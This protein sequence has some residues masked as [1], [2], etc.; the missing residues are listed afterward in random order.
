MSARPEMESHDDRLSRWVR[1]HGP[2]VAGYLRRFVP[3][4]H[5]L[6]DLVQ[7]TF[8]RA[9]VDRQKYREQE[10]ERGY[11]IQIADRLLIDSRRQRRYRISTELSCDQVPAPADM[12]PDALAA[13]AEDSDQLV[14][15]MNA[16]SEIQ[17]R[18]LL[19][20]YYGRLDFAQVASALGCPV[21]TALS[22]ARRGLLALRKILV[23][24]VL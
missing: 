9:W 3:D 15:A 24:V 18:V 22:H 10:R 14:V 13:V 20:R 21:N 16:L 6:D 17:R 2:A 11:L 12:E 4:S 5:A 1:E 7:E 23:E 19:L 8:Y